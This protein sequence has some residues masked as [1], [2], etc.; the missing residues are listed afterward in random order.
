MRELLRRVRYLIHRGRFERELADEMAFHRE[1]TARELEGRGLD[2]RDAALASRRAFGS[3]AL[4]EDQARDVWV[5]RWLQDFS[6]DCRFAA[7][8]LA[9]ERRFT[10]VAATVLG[11][12][13]GITNLQAVLIN[14][15]CVRGLPVPRVDRV[16]FLAARDTQDREQPLSPREFRDLRSTIRGLSGLAAFATTPMVIGDEGQA[17]D[18]ALGAYVSA[19]A[20]GILAERPLIGRDFEPADDKPG[21]P[22]VAILAHTLW[23]SRYGA[24][25]SIVGRTVRVDGAPA[26]I[27]GV[28]RDRFRF[29]TNTEIWRPLASMPDI[30]GA[31]RTTR[32]LGVFG[33]L[34]DHAS[35][36]DVRGQLAASTRQMSHDYP[37][38]NTGMRLAVVPINEKFN[39]RITDSVWLAFISVGV[40]VLLIACANTANLL[41]MRS[42]TRGHEMA[43]RASLGASR[44][45]LVRQLLVESVLLAVLGGAL[46]TALSAAGLH[47]LSNMVPPNTLPYWVT[48]TMD[49]RVFALLCAICLGTVFVFGFAPAVHTSRTDVGQL[50]KS[51]SRGGGASVRVRRWT[52]AFLAAEFGL[53]MVMVAALLVNLRAS[54]A[55]ERRELVVDPTNLVTSAVTLSAERYRTPERRL[56][57]YE[58]LDTRLAQ[59]PSL[60][61]TAVA[62]ALPLGGA[63]AQAVEIEGQ[64]RPSG[65]LAP[66]VWAVAI[67]DRYFDVLSIPLLQGRAFA[68]RD[69][70]AGYESVIVNQ[71]FARAFFPGVDSIGRH[72]RLT[73]TRAPNGTAPWLT[74]VGV[75]AIVRQRS[76]SDPDPIVYL[77]LNAGPPT[78][79]RL[80][81][82]APRAAAVVAPLLRDAV[83]AIDPDL[84]LYRTMSMD[85]A[86]AESQWNGR[87]SAVI[88]DGIVLVAIC[89]AGVGVYAV[90]SYAVVQRTHEIGIRM[91]LGARRQHIVAIVLR[92]AAAQLGIGLLTGVACMRAWE[93]LFGEGGSRTVFY[94]L[95][96]PINLIGVAALLT[97]IAGIA[98]VL[99]ARRAVALDPLVSVRHE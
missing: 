22:G 70:L 69:G 17:P 23:A 2:S 20:F 91:A 11:L 18:R 35:I 26:V 46:G 47:A 21:A 62:T 7:R 85:Q 16:V 9:K 75:S 54:H 43:L 52:T 59:I 45:Q 68:S 90:T 86:L 50:V 10:V 80:I 8:L 49:R 78:S 79:A 41:L 64:A 4:G 27:V 53:T 97:L 44:S 12:G 37:D 6:R 14:D 71:Q 29:P 84:P 36:G 24:D 74:I 1:M 73:E 33:R 32:A 57:F 42:A 15:I 48:F 72:I 5:W 25:P 28:M 94:H 82:R 51:G 98:C 60:S 19:N 13:I 56:A 96:D 81:V 95:T 93:R 77:P 40:I 89:L 38:T 31:K 67:S 58:Q 65:E 55:A 30:A 63:A 92:R 88:L 39:G 61:G 99:P 66:I 34:E 76:T 87:V 83:R 3:G